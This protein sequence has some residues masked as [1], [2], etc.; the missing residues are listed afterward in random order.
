MT[1]FAGI[2]EQLRVAKERVRRFDQLTRQRG[3][4]TGQLGQVRQAVADLRAR[5]AD[6]EGDVTRLESGFAGFLAKLVGSKEERLTQERAEVEAARQRLDGQRA[7]VASLEADLAGIDGELARLGPVHEEYARLLADKERLL[8]ELADPRGQE[9]ADL[10]VRLGDRAADL[11]EHDEAQR[12]G[13]AVGRE[14]S[15]VLDRLNS[16][17]GASQWDVLGGGY[18][19]DAVERTRLE[20]A[21]QAAWRAQRQL[22]VF[23]RELAD[24][25]I[26]GGPRLPEVDTRWFVDTFLD[27]IITDV[28]KHQQINETRD[29]VAQVAAWA[30]ATVAA[31]AR[32]SGELSAERAALLARRDE[33]LAPTADREI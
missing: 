25:G 2:D 11:R 26:A 20:E 5:L 22:D 15:Y 29:A 16:A 21:D 14:L 13:V 19:A 32:R 8:I 31:I 33:L 3:A 9:L 12:A 7:R 18:M 17:S 4:V 10:A 1:D 30:D 27:N 23:S 28:L 24:I 6:E